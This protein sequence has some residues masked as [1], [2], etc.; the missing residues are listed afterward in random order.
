ME[1]FEDAKE[2]FNVEMPLSLKIEKFQRKKLL[3]GLKPNHDAAQKESIIYL[4]SL[5]YIQ[6]F[7]EGTDDLT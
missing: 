2:N 6:Q 7:E 3:Q 4:Q 1:A 5:K